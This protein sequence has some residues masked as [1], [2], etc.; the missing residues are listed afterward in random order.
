MVD[1]TQ[2]FSE[3]FVLEM[4]NNH[5]GRLERG[6]KIIE[7]FSK[8]AN[9]SCVKAAIK[10][11]L[12]DVDTFIHPDFQNEKRI[13]YV[14][15]TQQTQ[16]SHAEF[17]ILTQAILDHGLI[18]MATV[19]DEKSVAFAVDLGLP[20]LKLASSDLCDHSLIEALI[21]TQKPLIASTGGAQ[22]FQIDAL[23]E[24]YKQANI[25]LALNHCVSLYPSE[26]DELELNQIELL[27]NRYPQLVIGFSSHEYH[28]WSASLLMSYA[29]G[30]RTWERHI[31]LDDGE[32]DLSP[33]CS[34][35]QNISQWFEAFHLAKK[36]CG[37]TS[38]KPMVRKQA[39]LNYLNSLKRGVYLKRDLP[40]GYVFSQRSLGHDYYL[41]IPLQD[42]QLCSDDVLQGA[43]LIDDIGLDQPL[44]GHQIENINSEK[45]KI[46]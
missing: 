18:P 31:D 28:D 7:D 4:A 40:K 43:K 35:P 41:A 6:L 22:I 16:L 8:V 21:H 10:F 17:K 25:P 42:G 11:Q 30:A 15:K 39:E 3:L 9:K 23:V 44:L 29:K 27:K 38:Q 5:W 14:W 1:A 45:V 2:L 12:R 36:M 34:T 19:F 20:I 32:F 37:G 33:Y 24:K 46:A 26:D 13:R